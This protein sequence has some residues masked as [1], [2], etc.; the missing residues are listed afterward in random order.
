[1]HP[2]IQ[3]DRPASNAKLSRLAP[4]G[5]CLAALSVLAAVLAG[6]GSQWHWWHFRRGFAIL[7]CAAYGG[8]AAAILSGVGVAAGKGSR[9]WGGLAIFAGLL[10]FLIPWNWKRQARAVPA[11]HDITTDPDDPPAFFAVLPLR[12][13]AS[14]PSEYGGPKIAA[15][16]RAAYPDLAPLRMDLPPDPTLVRALDAARSL[17]WKIVAVSPRAGRLEA[18]DRTF[19]FGFRDDIVVRVTADGR[20]SRLDVRSVSRVGKGDAGTNARRIRTF[21]KRIQK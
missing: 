5:F 14:N 21:L 11:I 13:G 1:M 19:W 10:I 16:Q 6:F 12:K 9:L 7:Q 15:L 8:L 20:G 18:T 4:W 2:W 3:A 17:G